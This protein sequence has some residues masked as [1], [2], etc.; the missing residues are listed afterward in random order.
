MNSVSGSHPMGNNF[1][2][3]TGSY[4]GPRGGQA[5]GASVTG[6][7][8]N[9]YDAGVAQGPRGGVAAGEGVQGANG[10]S[11]AR[12]AAVGP[13][14]GMAAGGTATGPNGASA[15]RGAAVG[16]NGRAVAGSSVTGPNGATASRG[17]AVG[18]NGAVAG[19]SITGPNGASAARGYG[20]YSP[21]GQYANAAAVRNNFNGYG[22]YNSGWYGAHPGAWYAAGWASGAAWTAATWP[23]IG[24]WFG[25]GS[26]V[27]PVSYDYGS[28]VVYQGD[29]VYVNGQDVGTS[30]QYYQQAQSLA[31]TGA[32]A[33]PSSDVQW[34]P[35]GVF[36]V[37][38]AGQ[39]TQIGTLQLAVDKSATIRGNYTD[40]STD[41]T[42]QVQGSVDKQTQRVAFTIGD[43]SSTVIETGLYNLTKDQA[44]AL[45]HE[46]KDN[47]EQ[48]LLVRM[49]QNGQSN[50]G[51]QQGQ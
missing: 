51:G 18:P 42:Q 20:Y 22:Y 6:P 25:Y 43:D 39:S 35:L 46:G 23:S 2:V 17:A 10:G 5:A 33:Q 13:N 48:W 8:G 31:S 1:D 34:M 28:S 15:S 26:Y 44:N 11:A 24:G 40:S 12:G 16:P 36:A 50:S 29:N 37:S 9:T 27:Q 4:T 30:D 47:T 38:I 32:Q 3:N 45:V 41:K 19:S 7:R 21:S 14:G 49:Q